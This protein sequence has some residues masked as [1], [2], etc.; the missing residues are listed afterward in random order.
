MVFVFG[1]AG[2][3]GSALV[4]HC[5]Q[6]GI[7]HAGIIR[8]NYAEYVGKANDLFINAAGNSSKRLANS[9]PA[10]DFEKNVAATLKS[11]LDFPT[12]RYVYLSTIDVYHD[13]RNPAINSETAPLRPE[14][15]SRYG[16]HKYLAELLV[17]KY[18]PSH[19]LL[20]LGG[21]VGPN[22]KKNAVYDIA[23]ENR[24]FVHPQSKYQYLH[25]ARVAEVVFAAAGMS[26]TNLLLNVC[27]D[28]LVTPEQIQSW[29]GRNIIPKES[30][31]EHYEINI[32]KL[33]SLFEV[34]SSEFSVQR[35]LRELGVIGKSN[36]A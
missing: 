11:I 17:R 4:E 36:E 18:C 14:S 31:L 8:Q 12:R 28:G 33:K 10:A 27:G 16:F 32:E 15:M 24:L 23:V 5:R 21:M 13:V 34:S 3:V 30:P 22:L 20:R 2:F 29:L 35:Y 19:A 26:T 1:A 6:N 9:D 25:T 7:P